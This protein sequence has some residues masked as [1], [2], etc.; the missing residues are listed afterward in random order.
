MHLK[1]RLLHIQA[2]GLNEESLAI[3][4]DAFGIAFLLK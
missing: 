2:S 3:I 4:L 1:H